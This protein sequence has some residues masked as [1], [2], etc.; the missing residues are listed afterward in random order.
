MDL[1][2]YFML[3]GMYMKECGTMIRLTVREHTNTKM[4][5]LMRESGKRINSTVTGL[6]LGLMAQSIREITLKEKSMAQESLSSQTGLSMR[7]SSR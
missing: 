2:N 3:M 5:Q 6:S 7:A 4:E 1:E